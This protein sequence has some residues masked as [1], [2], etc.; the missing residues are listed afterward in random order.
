MATDEFVHESLQDLKSIGEYLRAIIQGLESGYL[1][2]SD[3]S[4]QLVLHPS[5]LLGL[6]LRA[7]RKGNRAKL[8]VEL[9]WT[10]DKGTTRA[11]SLRVRSDASG[12]SG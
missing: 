3:D 11:E 4:G 8:E 10:E 12:R 9:S 7:R 5:G 6:E 1:D 2:L